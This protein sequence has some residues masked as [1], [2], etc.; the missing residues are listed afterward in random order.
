MLKILDEKVLKTDD[1]IEELYKDCK[2][3]CIID[4][5]DRVADNNG[6]LYCVSTD[7]DSFEELVK[8]SDRLAKVGKCC[9]IGGSYNDGG[10]VG[11]QYEVKE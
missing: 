7:K 8:E 3:L 10:A 2:Y 9:V 6:Y 5:Y 4:S 11:V 1:E